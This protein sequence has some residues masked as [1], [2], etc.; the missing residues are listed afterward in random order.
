MYISLVTISMCSFCAF[1]A[2]MSTNTIVSAESEST[3]VDLSVEE[4]A[5][6]RIVHEVV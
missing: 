4:R 1:C 6:V 2:D 3:V 5:Q